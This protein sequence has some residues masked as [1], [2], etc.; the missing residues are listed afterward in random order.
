MAQKSQAPIV[1]TNEAP[2]VETLEYTFIENVKFKSVYYFKGDNLRCTP[3]DADEL[4][5]NNL[6]K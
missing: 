4:I 5:R 3:E 1:E 6:V 2:I